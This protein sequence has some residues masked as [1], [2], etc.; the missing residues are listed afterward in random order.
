MTNK[1]STYKDLLEEKDRLQTSLNRQKDVLRADIRGIK[2][3]FE[4]VRAALGVLKKFTRKDSSNPML[5]IATGRIISLVLNKLVLGRAGWFAKLAVPFLAKNISTH[6]IADNK[7]VIL[8][9]LATWFNKVRGHRAK[10]ATVRTSEY[11]QTVP[12]YQQ[13]AG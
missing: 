5:N 6:V 11:Q 8:G 1:I 3:E 9:K 4:P 7:T 2:E 10:K 13:P 12:G